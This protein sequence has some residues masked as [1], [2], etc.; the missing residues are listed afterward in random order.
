M[1]SM[2]ALLAAGFVSTSLA[3]PQS[4]VMTVEAIG[5]GMN[6]ACQAGGGKQ[7]RDTKR[8]AGDNHGEAPKT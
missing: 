8:D 2:M 6:A 4:T 3:A 7:D 1:P 5:F